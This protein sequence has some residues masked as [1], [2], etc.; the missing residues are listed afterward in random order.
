[1][2]VR[3]FFR[4]VSKETR[5]R[6]DIPAVI[7]TLV[8]GN[9]MMIELDQ[10]PTS[11]IIKQILNILNTEEWEMVSPSKSRFNI[12]RLVKESWIRARENKERIMRK[13][14]RNENEV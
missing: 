1:M 6:R 11:K 13:A 5:L 3:V 7:G 8:S 4:K 12:R 14:M 2:V 9:T 10:P